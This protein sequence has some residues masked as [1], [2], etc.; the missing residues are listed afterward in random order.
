MIPVAAR[1]RGFG[2]GNR[3]VPYILY[4]DLIYLDNL[5]GIASD[6]LGSRIKTS[7]T[8]VCIPIDPSCSQ[9]KIQRSGI[10]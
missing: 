4:L 10:A 3:R 7:G 2:I 5:L 1:N 6:C 9:S 8:E